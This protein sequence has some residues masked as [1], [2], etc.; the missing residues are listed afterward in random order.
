MT[1]E[2]Y[3][4][5]KKTIIRA[6]QEKESEEQAKVGESEDMEVERQRKILLF[7]LRPSA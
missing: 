6:I 5:I 1:F 3:V 4:N 7:I 2:E